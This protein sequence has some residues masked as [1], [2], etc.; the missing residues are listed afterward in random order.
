MIHGSMSL[1]LNK[2]K[3][4]FVSFTLLLVA[5]S[6]QW[7][8]ISS[9]L[10]NYVVQRY[11]PSSCYSE[12]EYDHLRFNQL[13][14]EFINLK[15]KISNQLMEVKVD[16]PK[17][18]V[19]LWTKKKRYQ[20]PK[21]FVEYSP[22][23]TD[24]AS[25]FA[26]LLLS[27]LDG[28]NINEIDLKI[29]GSEDV[30]L[31]FK[32]Q[33]QH[34]TVGAD[35]E[36]SIVLNYEEKGAGK[37]IKCRCSN[38]DGGWLFSVVKAL[39]IQQKITS[40][41][42]DL[43]GSCAIL[44]QQNRKT[45]DLISSLRCKGL[46]IT[47]DSQHFSSPFACVDWIGNNLPVDL[48][49]I[50]ALKQSF[51]H[52]EVSGGCYKTKRG[53]I[54]HIQG[55]VV[56][57]AEEKR[58]QLQGEYIDGAKRLPC[59]LKVQSTHHNG[60]RLLIDGRFNRC[61]YFSGYATK[62]KNI[63]GKFFISHSVLLSL[64]VNSC[65]MNIQAV[66]PNSKISGMVRYHKEKENHFIS[67]NHLFA[68]HLQVSPL[69][70]QLTWEIP[71]LSGAI[72]LFFDSQRISF[73]HVD[74]DLSE[75]K[76]RCESF[77]GN[78]PIDVEGKLA[79][80]NGEFD[81]KIICNMGQQSTLLDI[82]GKAY[83]PV[84]RMHAKYEQ[85]LF[86]KQFR[87]DQTLGDFV[88][89]NAVFQ[90]INGKWNGKIL[91]KVDVDKEPAEEVL[92]SIKGFSFE[93]LTE[94]KSSYYEKIN[95]HS[96]IHSPHVYA[97]LSNQLQF[98]FQW[99]TETVFDGMVTPKGV[100]GTLHYN[101]I[102]FDCMYAAVSSN[103]KGVGRLTYDFNTKETEIKLPLHNCQF[104]EKTLDLDFHNADANFLYKKNKVVF[105]QI[106]AL[107]G[108]VALEGDVAIDWEKKFFLKTTVSHLH[109]SVKGVSDFISQCFS[110]PLPQ[111]PIEG[112]VSSDREIK[113]SV[114]GEEVIWDAALS[115]R[116]G[117]GMIH[118]VSLHQ[119]EG[120]IFS[121][122]HALL[123]SEVKAR[124]GHEQ[125]PYSVKIEK[126]EIDKSHSICFS[127][128]L[129][130]ELYDIAKGTFTLSEQQS[131]YC[132]K[133]DRLDICSSTCSVSPWYFN[134]KHQPHKGELKWNFTSDDCYLLESFIKE[135]S[136]I[137]CSLKDF[138]Q[139][140]G[141]GSLVYQV[142][143][144]RDH[145][146]DLNFLLH[147]GNVPCQ[148][149]N[150]QC[151]YVQG[152]WWGYLHDRDCKMQFSGHLEEDKYCIKA[153]QCQWQDYT[154][155]INDAYTTMDSKK[156]YAPFTVK[157]HNLLA[158]GIVES[159]TD[160]IKGH[161]Q[162]DRA[163]IENTTLSTIRPALFSYVKAT[164]LSLNKSELFIDREKYP[165]NI[166]LD[167]VNITPQGEVIFDT[168][169]TKQLLEQITSSSSLCSYLDD[170]TSMQAKLALIRQKD[171]WEMKGH[172]EGCELERIGVVCSSI[173]LHMQQDIMKLSAELDSPFF[174]GNVHCNLVGDSLWDV[175][176]VGK[177]GR[178][179]S[180]VQYDLNQ[181][182]L[183]SLE[184]DICGCFLKAYTQEDDKISVKA[185][186]NPLVLRKFAGGK[187]LDGLGITKPFSILGTYHQDE[188]KGVF[189]ATN[190]T[191]L[192]N[193]LAS[194]HGEVLVDNE[195]MNIDELKIVDESVR[196]S[197]SS[198]HVDYN[199]DL[200]IEK[201]RLYNLR[202][203]LLKSDNKT[204]KK[205]KP[206]VI[207]KLKFDHIY[208]NIYNAPSIQGA[209][210]L[211]FQNSFHQGTKSFFNIP[212]ELISRLGLDTGLLVPLQGDIN[213]DIDQ[214]KIYLTKLYN[215][216]SEGKHS[217]FYFS[218]KRPS[219]V[220][221]DGNLSVNIKMRQNVLLRFTQIFTLT[222]T[223]ELEKP[224]F[225][226]K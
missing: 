106:K 41:K 52:V 5:V 64:F 156:G 8:W 40:F 54:D 165:L 49:L 145:K 30:Q 112:M 104:K 101:G 4:F 128:G 202:P 217:S 84:I 107:S 98:P 121:S 184:G 83:E 135:I 23:K 115:L 9:S 31:H 132:I 14:I 89:T 99:K 24:L 71:S 223:G 35:K 1:K 208:G 159:D 58:A 222:I 114:L 21:A 20:V 174:N 116:E 212:Y 214:G 50:T 119:L 180:L 148:P 80:T 130:H 69:Q 147:K 185:T 131:G 85:D 176:A 97:F 100:E 37:R 78:K 27:K 16:L 196:G 10:I 36:R 125:S 55:G 81:T 88:S 90:P 59:T 6:S 73:S 226:L 117:K 110:S 122:P 198:I 213:M 134:H 126:G 140:S 163:V 53:V 103:E 129:H 66:Q 166:T 29:C 186:V 92:L 215:C 216:Y 168:I 44:V 182:K 45:I 190:F 171:H 164:G 46:D 201:M 219:Y 68:E 154:V 210:K 181:W 63:E 204:R 65:Q 17:V 138:K 57:G 87:W 70:T 42:G 136:D 141:K 137:S 26:P 61:D 173:D 75:N 153:A 109:G 25:S 191:L 62:D 144:D 206:F 94:K 177:E 187:C 167:Q 150:L 11:L 124:I 200:D 123:I 224:V 183:F 149:L 22:K 152:F 13:G 48:P 56:Y 203:S 51:V 157:S 74:L 170:N 32:N 158:Q 207:N 91:L 133:A 199:G 82:K 86:A 43:E 155:S 195:G 220:D 175:E 12:C 172:L 194:V 127:G 178:V 105:S 162:I 151:R 34:W 143:T 15:G 47:M 18:E 221:F 3:F 38:L 189:Q 102:D 28:L 218:S 111:I 179:R 79:L 188:F 108:M 205:I 209:G 60:Q 192:N 77:L 39:G 72:E 142:F 93:E 76:V 139:Y 118:N 146:L 169:L 211:H 7:S 33:G 225:G 160:I 193:S 95:I 2:T 113:L 120:K 67:V 19:S 197:I 96:K 161:V